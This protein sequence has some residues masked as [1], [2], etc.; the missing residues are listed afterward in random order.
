MLVK[1]AP[2]LEQSRITYVAAGPNYNKRPYFDGLVQDVS[3]SSVLAMEILES[4]TKPSISR[5]GDLPF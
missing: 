4:C 1:G 3:I 2:E 5:N